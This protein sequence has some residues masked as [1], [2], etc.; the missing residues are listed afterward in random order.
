MLM[1]LQDFSHVD[2]PQQL[3]RHNRARTV[4]RLANKTLALS[5]QVAF[6]TL[7]ERLIMII[8]LHCLG[9]NK[10]ASWFNFTFLR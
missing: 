1:S 7:C 6:P 5:R 10:L 2:S 8:S 9:N 4:W 3:R